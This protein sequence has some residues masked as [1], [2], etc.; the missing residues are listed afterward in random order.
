M[1]TVGYIRVS[2]DEQIDGYS[3]SAQEKAIR[4]FANLRGWH[5]S[6]IY[7]EAGRSAKDDKRPQFQQMIEDAKQ[8]HFDV[9]AVHKLDRFSRSLIDCMTYLNMLNEHKV[10]FVSVTEDFDFT[11][12][13]GKVILAMLAAFAQWYL[14]NL[15]NEVSKGKKERAR[16]GGWNGTLSF[17]YTT[18]QR[19]REKS[20]ALDKKLKLGDI[21]QE[22]YHEERQ[23][24]D[25]TLATYT[26]LSDTDA[27]PCPFD[28]PAVIL[29]YEAYATGAESDR[30]IAQLLNDSGYR[31]SSRKKN[32]PFLTDTVGNILKN[33]FYIGMT[34]YGEKVKGLERKWIQGIHDSIISEDLFYTVQSIREKRA[35]RYNAQRV[36]KK[37]TYPL[38]S[39]LKSVEPN[40]SWRG[41]V[42]RG[43]RRYIRRAV[44]GV[45]PGKVI[46]A[47]DLE[48]NIG[49]FLKSLQ[50][51]Q[52][53]QSMIETKPMNSKPIEAKQLQAKRKQ[54]E[55]LQNLYLL[56]DI[57][58]DDFLNQRIQYKADIENLEARVFSNSEQII[59]MGR[60]IENVGEVWELASLEEKQLLTKQL[61]HYVYM[62]D[63]E[64][65]AVEP[66]AILWELLTGTTYGE[67]RIR[68]CGTREGT[69][70]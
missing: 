61:F 6:H 46:F 43:K 68:T 19:L 41:Q 58:E 37:N 24:I 12:P 57:S 10:A 3:L 49:N 20:I 38:T 55:R 27:I 2:T 52:N 54:L 9:I 1:K 39:V 69:T 45:L 5:I 15:S 31:I 11:T 64:I 47:E 32:S 50:I 34:S 40:G 17:G 65:V 18:P 8:G 62:K 25:K 35:E 14:D 26:T 51:P 21:D 13:I 53:W 36:G 70:A 56:G 22:N 28:S 4:D 7:I 23:L 44:P 60:L 33:K 42:A 29:A 66:S 59:K 16:K 67:D 30:S 63:K 48:N